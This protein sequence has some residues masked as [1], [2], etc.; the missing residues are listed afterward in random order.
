MH[1]LIHTVWKE[2]IEEKYGPEVWRK[3]LQACDVQDDTEF[4]EFKQHEDKL[5]HQVMSASMGVA[6]ISLEASLEL[7]GAYFVQF[8]VRQG[9]TQWLQA[10]GSSLQEFVQNLNDMHHVLERDFRSAC[11]PIFTAS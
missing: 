8:M 9:W 3:A 11:F 2:F 5:T 10:M 1:G 4:L 7:F 6:A